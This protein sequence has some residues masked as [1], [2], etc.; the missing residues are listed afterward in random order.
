MSDEILFFLPYVREYRK[1]ISLG[2]KALKDHVFSALMDSLPE[3]VKSGYLS[4]YPT[5]Y[6]S[7][8]SPTKDATI[9]QILGSGITKAKDSRPCEDIGD[10]QLFSVPGKEDY[11]YHP[12]A[13]RIEPWPRDHY[14]KEIRRKLGEG[15]A[16]WLAVNTVNSQTIYKPYCDRILSDD[17]IGT[18]HLNL[19]GKPTWLPA[20]DYKED[21]SWVK[22]KRLDK[23]V[24][25]FFRHLIPGG[26]PEPRAAVYGWIRDA[27][28]TRSHTILC[29]IGAQ[30]T[31]KNVLVTDI[32]GGC[33]NG[34]KT[35]LG[36]KKSHN[37]ATAQRGS[38]TA[39]FHSNILNT[40]LYNA[41][42][43]F[44]AGSF[45]ETLKDFAGDEAS[46]ESKNK[47]LGA[48]EIM[49]ASISV[50]NNEPSKNHLEPKDRRFLVADLTN[51]DLRELW[52]VSKIL[53]F[54]NSWSEDPEKCRRFCSF[55]YQNF[56][57]NSTGGPVYK[58]KLFYD[59]CRSSIPHWFQ[60]VFE[61][62]KAKDELVLPLRYYT[63]FE[64]V[65]ERLN[66]YEA[67]YGVSIATLERISDLRHPKVR[68]KSKIKGSKI[69]IG[70]QHAIL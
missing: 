56:P 69:S 50:T 17:E 12:A 13:D 54:K 9:L 19:W 62:V 32:L 20:R 52:S 47:N 48:P 36:K 53:E 35:N 15:A 7:W 70:D 57:E 40:Q 10:I 46:P 22:E 26:D 5:S 6:A 60:A 34:G 29:L 43:H 42:E 44:I 28:F 25:D 45:K 31:G 51:R 41:N 66:W 37:T 68:I 33:L 16:N 30:G 1:K 38:A 67:Q 55:L 24:L 8:S 21:L 18:K 39:T 61:E 2:T 4:D 58:G 65:Q 27:I 11:V 64:S 3:G 63:T 59:I 14:E 49:T 23:D